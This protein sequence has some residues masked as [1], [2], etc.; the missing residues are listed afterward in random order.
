MSAEIIDSYDKSQIGIKGTV[1]K[2]TKNL[3]ILDDNNHVRK[4][5]KKVSTFR[6]QHGR[7]SFVVN[8]EEINFRSYERTEK[9]LKFYKRRK[10]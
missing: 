7:Q 2:E 3:L 6:F 1:I 4:I 10:L 9:A 8:G 5:V